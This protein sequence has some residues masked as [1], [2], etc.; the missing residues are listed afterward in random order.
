M[1]NRLPYLAFGLNATLFGTYYA[2]AK[3]ALLR[4]DPLVFTA[5]EQ[6]T[7]I[8][9]AVAILWY[10]RRHLTG[11]LLCWGLL[12]GGCLA[13][14]FVVLACALAVT[15]AAA[16]AFSPALSG[17]LAALLIGA[18]Q[19]RLPQRPTLLAGVLSLGGLLLLLTTAPAAGVQGTLFAVLGTLLFTCYVLLAERVP[20]AAPRHAL[21]G[22]ELA[23]MGVVVPLAALLWGNWTACR[24]RLPHDGLIVLYLAVACTLVPVVLTVRFQAT[25]S[26]VTVAFLYTLEPVVGALLAFLYGGAVLPLGGYTGGALVVAG[27]LLHTWGGLYT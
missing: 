5:L 12:L 10:A 25:V 24:L 17:V 2:V 1:S 27:M 11:T 22:L 16:T 15:S 9:A 7:L 6:V 20:P 8:P 21:A 23:T 3:E 13:G 14:A 18:G 26:A 19:R 4:S